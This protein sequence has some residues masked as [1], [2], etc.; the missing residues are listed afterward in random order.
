MN[1]L[2][3]YEQK[4]KNIHNRIGISKPARLLL[5]AIDDLQAGAL[6][7]SELRRMIRI[8]PG[9]RN[10]ISQT[11]SDIA[12]FIINHPEESKTG[13]ILIQLLTKILQVADEI[14]EPMLPFMKF[15]R[16][17]RDLI[18]FYYLH[19]RYGQHKIMYPGTKKHT[20]PC[21]HAN[22]PRSLR[23]MQVKF[24]HPDLRN[25]MRMLTNFV[26]SFLR[27]LNK[28]MALS[29]VSKAIRED[30]M[31]VFYREHKFYFNCTCEMDYFIKN[32]KALQR[33]LVSIKIHWCGPRADKAFQALKTCPNLR[34]LVVVPSA[35]TTRYLVPRQQVFNRFFAHTS[36]PR[37]TDALG[38]D[39]LITLRGI[40]TVSVQH[41]PGRQGQKRTNEELANLNEI[42]QKYVKQD[43]EIG[44]GEE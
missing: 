25:H 21:S 17:V 8:S 30:F 2:S 22:Q 13:A 41:V 11:I 29:E 15:P 24:T 27:W 3:Y 32:N 36:R 23:D 40:S 37:L 6:E 38:K 43:K 1:E 31:A 35:A 9:Y 39:E 5:K 28:Q 16:E 26:L 20:C 44:Y 19:C 34:Q 33:N 10:I 7:E 4:T 42:L 18:Y 14:S 12:D